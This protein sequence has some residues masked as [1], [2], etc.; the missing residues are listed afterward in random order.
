[1]P[2][3]VQYNALM[4]IK[5]VAGKL[6]VNIIFVAE[7][8]EERMSMGFRKFMLDHPEKF[9]KADAVFG[10]GGSGGLFYIEVTTKGAKWHNGPNY[11]DIHGSNKRTV[12]SP[13]WRHMQMLSTLVDPVTQKVKIPG[14]YD[15][16]APLTKEQE[17]KLHEMAKKVNLKEQAK[18][19][20]V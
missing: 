13:A 3:V 19:I 7:G 6:P 15:N 10:G 8:D 14:F 9:A 4:S 11:S 1:G 5:A 16:V 2:E 12:L 20:G 17:A 18:N